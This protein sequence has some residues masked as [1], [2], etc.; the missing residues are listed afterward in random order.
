MTFKGGRRK[1]SVEREIA[2]GRETSFGL[3]ME[4]TYLDLK[5][6]EKKCEVIFRFKEKPFHDIFFKSYKKDPTTAD[7]IKQ[8]ENTWIILGSGGTPEDPK[9]YVVAQTKDYSGLCFTPQFDK[10]KISK[11]R[12]AFGAWAKWVPS[13]QVD[14]FGKYSIDEIFERIRK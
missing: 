4:L 12:I 6:Q 10:G 2:A 1:E 7:L 9:A 14:I 13:K 3:N 8:F 5:N 11:Y